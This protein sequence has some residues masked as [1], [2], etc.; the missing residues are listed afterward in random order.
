[1]SVASTFNNRKTAEQ[2]LAA[3]FFVFRQN[4]EV[5]RSIEF[6]LLQSPSN[7]WA[8]PKGHLESGETAIDA[9]YREVEEESGL[10]KEAVKVYDEAKIEL[11]YQ[12]NYGRPKTVT[13]WLAELIDKSAEVRI[14][15][16]HINYKWFTVD[17]AIAAAQFQNM[18]DGI[19][20]AFEKV[21]ALKAD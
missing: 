5:T 13:Y 21:Q 18:K 10:K 3:G 9:A 20:L 11:S 14:S 4:Q 7:M 19:R 12:N 1:M 17:E 16:E 2:V 15:H 8:P 6:L